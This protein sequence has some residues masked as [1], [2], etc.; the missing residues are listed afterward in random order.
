[1]SWYGVDALGFGSVEHTW[2]ELHLGDENGSILQKVPNEAGAITWAWGNIDLPEYDHDYT[3]AAWLEY[4]NNGKSENRA[5]SHKIYKKFRSGKLTFELIDSGIRGDAYTTIPVTDPIA[6][7]FINK[8]YHGER[9]IHPGSVLYKCGIIIEEKWWKYVA[10]IHWEL[11]NAADPDW[12][13]TEWLQSP[14]IGSGSLKEQ[15]VGYCPWGSYLDKENK[16]HNQNCN[17]R[18]VVTLTNGVQK[19]F[20]IW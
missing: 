6:I 5:R 15:I 19:A 12:Q 4:K 13:P 14:A 11:R 17:V 16:T 1:M 7:D 18:C 8:A 9:L 10:D 20:Q 3:L 2:F